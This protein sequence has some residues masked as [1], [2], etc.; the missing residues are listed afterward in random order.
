MEVDAQP[1]GGG[2][3]NK[4]RKQWLQQAQEEGEKLQDHMKKQLACAEVAIQA[5]QDVQEIKLCHHN[6]HNG[7]KSGSAGPLRRAQLEGL[8]PGSYSSDHLERILAFRNLIPNEMPETDYMEFLQVVDRFSVWFESRHA[9]ACGVQVCEEDLV[10]RCKEL[11]VHVACKRC[12]RYWRIPLSKGRAAS[13]RDRELFCLILETGQT[14]LRL[15]DLWCPQLSAGQAALSCPVSVSYVGGF[16]GRGEME[17]DAQPSGGG[18]IQHAQRTEPSSDEIVEE[19]LHVLQ[20][21]STCD[22]YANMQTSQDIEIEQVRV[23]HMKKL[24][25]H[26]KKH[27]ACAEVACHHNGI[28]SASAGP[29][30]RAQ[31]EGSAPGSYAPVYLTRMLVNRNL[32]PITMPETERMVSQVADRFSVWFEN[33][34]ACACGVQACGEEVDVHVH[35]SLACVCKELDVHVACKR[36]KRRWCIPLSKG[37]CA[38]AQDRDLF[39]SILESRFEQIQ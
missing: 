31:P 6:G 4:L 3:L 15:S 8:A 13:A 35:G 16:R 18:R 36:C 7:V 34:D 2:R 32:I 24:Q 1:S 20:H 19:M 22:N 12:K 11:D 14:S 27:L 5:V 33:R 9:C 29:L 17:V 21:A 23:Y 38:S 10:C 30:L 25:C 37:R 26:M 28:K 39:C